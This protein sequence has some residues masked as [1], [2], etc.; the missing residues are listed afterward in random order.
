[1]K[2]W[3]VRQVKFGKKMITNV[4]THYVSNIVCKATSDEHGGNAKL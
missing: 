4:P 2:R 3:R 1:M